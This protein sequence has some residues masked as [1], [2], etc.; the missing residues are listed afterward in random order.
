MGVTNGLQQILV[1]PIAAD[2]GP[3]TALVQLGYTNEDSATFTQDEPTTT[4]FFVEELDDPILTNERPGPTTF[5]WVIANPD[6]E[7]L[8]SLFGGEVTGAGTD[9]SP[10]VWN[11][12]DKVLQNIFRTVKIVPEVGFESITIPRAKISPRFD[13]TI[14]R[15][16]LF[17]VTVVATVH[18]PTKDGVG[19]FQFSET[20]PAE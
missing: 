17:G 10:R 19:R 11:A 1:G 18:K 4:E 12:P 20:D 6:A 8:Q 7:V 16:S 5:T 15:N 9:A 3:G 13:G 2:G 14:G